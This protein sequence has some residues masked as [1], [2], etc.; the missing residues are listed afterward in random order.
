MQYKYFSTHYLSDQLIICKVVVI[1]NLSSVIQP[2]INSITSR[3]EVR[4]SKLILLGPAQRCIA[5]SFLDDGME[6][7]QQEIETG[8]LIGSLWR[9]R[10]DKFS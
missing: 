3:A 1:S 4:L 8:T 10:K 2:G 9:H 5:Q 7:S 6:P